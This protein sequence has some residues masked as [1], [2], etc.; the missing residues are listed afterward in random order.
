MVGLGRET[1]GRRL[2]DAAFAEADRPLHMVCETLHAAG[3]CRMVQNRIGVGIVDP[4][5]ACDFIDQGVV[6]RRFEPTLMFHVALMYP[7][8]RPL[9]RAASEFLK[10]LRIHRN[11]LRKQVEALLEA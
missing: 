11:L 2:L 3:I 8:H 1:V 9:S 6:F 4:F 10:V 5:T 7:L